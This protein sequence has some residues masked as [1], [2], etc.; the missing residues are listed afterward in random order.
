MGCV[1]FNSTAPQGGPD[2]VNDAASGS[3]LVTARPPVPIGPAMFT[4][5]QLKTRTLDGR[6]WSVPDALA[7][8][9]HR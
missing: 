6:T 3:L 7:Q 1:E 5:S 8:I 2:A 9:P 4:V